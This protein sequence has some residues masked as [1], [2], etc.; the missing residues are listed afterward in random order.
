ML[1]REFESE[2]VTQL[3]WQQN[4]FS[5]LLSL[6]RRHLGLEEYHILLRIHCSSRQLFHS[7][8]RLGEFQRAWVREL[9]SELDAIFAGLEMGEFSCSRLHRLVHLYRDLFLYGRRQETGDRSQESGV[10]RQESGARSQ[11]PGARSQETG[12]RSQESRDRRARIQ[13]PE[14]VREFEG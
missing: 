9:K 2:W 14:V 4:R 5:V 7:P 13:K 3:R 1:S 8:R 11:E 10:R 12:A 6:L